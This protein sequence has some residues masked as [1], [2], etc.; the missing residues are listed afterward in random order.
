MCSLW[1]SATAWCAVRQTAEKTT[2]GF[3]E[4]FIILEVHLQLY[5]ALKVK[6]PLQMYK[7]SN[8]FVPE[9]SNR[10]VKAIDSYDIVSPRG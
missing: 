10:D 1:V 2:F 7:S 6:H 8:C 3:K 4:L 5:I 9:A